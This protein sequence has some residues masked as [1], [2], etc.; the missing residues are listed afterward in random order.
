M[1]VISNVKGVKIT[2]ELDNLILGCINEDLSLMTWEL[3]LKKIINKANDA[4]KMLMIESRLLVR[5]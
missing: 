5:V 1:C 2:Y 3:D 4:S